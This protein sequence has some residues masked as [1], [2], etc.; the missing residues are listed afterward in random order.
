MDPASL[1]FRAAFAARSDL[2]LMGR[3]PLTQEELVTAP[4]RQEI[5][6]R[7]KARPGMPLTELRAQLGVGW[8]ALYHHLRKLS[9]AG[10]IEV[11]TVGRLNLLYLKGAHQ[12]QQAQALALLRGTTAHRIAEAVIAQPGCS[13]RDLVERTGDSPRAVYYHVKR[14][15]DA[16]L[17]TS[18]SRFRHVDL[19]PGRDLP[20][21]LEAAR[22]AP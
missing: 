18:P 11:H 15:V 10:L 20:A 13:V 16:G 21:V 8:G 6:Q 7:A 4:L 17:L 3:N 5:L 9:A 1:L 12:S 19:Q 22:R 2:P 14:L